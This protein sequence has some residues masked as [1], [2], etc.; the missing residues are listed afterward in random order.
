VSLGTDGELVVY[1]GQLTG[2]TTQVVI[3]VSGYYH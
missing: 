1:V 2:T 3:D